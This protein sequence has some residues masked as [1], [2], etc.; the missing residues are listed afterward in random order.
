MYRSLLFQLLDRVP[1]LQD[2]LNSSSKYVQ[3]PGENHDWELKTLQK[4][5][6]Q[7]ISKLGMQRVT[8]FVDALDECDAEQVRDMI[9]TFEQIGQRG[10]SSGAQFY[11]CFSSRHYP[12]IQIDAGIQLALEDQTGHGE[13]ME[14]Y[15]RSKLKIGTSKAVHDI[16]SEI[17]RKAAGVFLWVVLV[18]DILEK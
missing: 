16:K 5:L 15:V 14:K 10:F 2:I 3:S 8:F 4:L 12:Y 9:E 6:S 18:V 7:A 17:I 13:D 11:V 1:K